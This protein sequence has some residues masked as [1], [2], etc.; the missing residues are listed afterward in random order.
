M[1][2]V[3]HDERLEAEVISNCRR[4]LNDFKMGYM[5]VAGQRRAKGSG[6]TLGF[7]DA[8]VYSKGRV[9]VVEFKRPHGG[10]LS[11]DQR[12]AIEARKREGVETWV[13]SNEQEFV[14]MICGRG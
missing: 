12:I 2:R 7:P 1:R 5:E 10:V 6:S 9:Y 14:D 13:I 4:W 8:V 11:E 3:E